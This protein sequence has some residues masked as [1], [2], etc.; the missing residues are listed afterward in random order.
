[1]EGCDDVCATPLGPDA[2]KADQLA[3]RTEATT[4]RAKNIVPKREK[5]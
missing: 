2:G 4:G 1:M 5:A 3:R